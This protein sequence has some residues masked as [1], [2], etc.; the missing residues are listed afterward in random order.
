MAFQEHKDD[1]KNQ[2][3]TVQYDKDELELKVNDLQTLLNQSKTNANITLPDVTTKEGWFIFY[4]SFKWEC[5]I[6]EY[7]TSHNY[8][9]IANISIQR[10]S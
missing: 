2:L 10:D 1:F 4:N 3:E 8:R 9:L 6:T 7:N 5:Y